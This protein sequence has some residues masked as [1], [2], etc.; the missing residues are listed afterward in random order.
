MPRGTL[1]TNTK[2]EKVIIAVLAV[3][4]LL[5]FR[6][7]WVIYV[8]HRIATNER[9]AVEK[10]LIDV[11]KRYADLSQEVKN[12]QTERGVEQSIREKFHVA[13]PGEKTVIL[14][15]PDD[16]TKKTDDTSFWGKLKSFFA[17]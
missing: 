13:K 17:K 6:G 11:Q 5:L 2:K 16:A 4:I 15:T 8:K 12:L 14:V 7:V 3:L 1:R 10:E 9:N